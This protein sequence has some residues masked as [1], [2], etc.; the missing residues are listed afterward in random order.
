MLNYETVGKCFLENPLAS[1]NL[2]CKAVI[3][4]AMKIISFERYWRRYGRETWFEYLIRAG[5]SKNYS[6]FK[7]KQNCSPRIFP[8]GKASLRFLRFWV[9]Q[10]TGWH[11]NVRMIILFVT[12]QK[13][14]DIGRLVVDIFRK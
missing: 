7:R 13:D 9:Y 14:S 8:P 2:T 5:S 12:G 4:T 3:S 6:N 11:G 10:A 1:E